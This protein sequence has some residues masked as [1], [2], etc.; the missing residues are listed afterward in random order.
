MFHN[1]FPKTIK[2]NLIK[3]LSHNAIGKFRKKE[4]KLYRCIQNPIKHLNEAFI[5]VNG[6]QLLSIFTKCS[7]LDI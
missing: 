5:V 6:P 3:R 1:I 2:D 4:R 7:I